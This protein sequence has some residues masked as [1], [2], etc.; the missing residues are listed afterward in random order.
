VELVHD[1]GPEVGVRA[2]A[3]RDV[4]ALCQAFGAENVGMVTGDSAVNADAPIVCC[5][6]EILARVA[7]ISRNWACGSSIS[8]TCQAQPRCGSA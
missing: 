4:G 7:D 8:G 2:L 1:D 6:A 3:Q 5:T